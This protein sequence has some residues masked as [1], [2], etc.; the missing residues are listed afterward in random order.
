MFLEYDLKTFVLSHVSEGWIINMSK[1][2]KQNNTTSA[3][4]NNLDDGPT[5]ESFD[6]SKLQQ[7]NRKPSAK[8]TS[9]TESSLKVKKITS[10]NK[11]NKTSDPASKEK[12]FD[13]SSNWLPKEESDKLWLPTEVGC[14]DLHPNWWSGSFKPIKSKSWF[15]VKRWTPVKKRKWP[16]TVSQSS[17]FSIAESVEGE[18]S[19]EAKQRTSK[20]RKSVKLV[21]NK[22]Q[23][24]GLRPTPEVAHTLKRWFGCVRYT[25]NW[26]L[27]C[28]KAKPTQYKLNMIW[29]RKRFINVCNIPKDKKFL[30]DTPKSIRDN[31]VSDLQDA[32]KSNFAI[33]KKNPNH[34]FDI[35]FR[36]KKD[37]QAITITSDQIKHWDTNKTEFSM[38]PTFLK[39]KI[40]FHVKKNKS[41]PSNVSY[42]CK[43]LMSRLGKFSLVIV[44]HDPPCENQTGKTKSCSIDPGVRTALT[45]YCPEPGI[46]YKIG[47]G[48]ISR[49]YRLCLWLDKLI[50]SQQNEKTRGKRLAILRLRERIRNLVTEFHCKAVHFLLSKFNVIIL[51]PFNVSQMVKKADR[52]I[53]TKTVRQMLSWRHYGFRQ[54]LLNAAKMCN[55]TI[56][57]RG[58]EY[59][60]KTCTHCRNCKHNLGGAKIYKCTECKLKADRDCCGARNIFI[61]NMKT[62]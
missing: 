26:A 51:P 12:V 39:N 13:P 2:Q 30:L 52:K 14:P 24:V 20:I 28:I 34:T 32:F 22:S 25:Y 7:S 55:A 33:K 50:S 46:C 57:I 59:T 54:R 15:S 41:V 43:L 44:F 37:A 17:T 23:R 38:F 10:K 19:K 4:A 40:K 8:K 3:S 62:T 45:I 1:L 42:D 9:T 56:Y 48:D 35:K 11:S 36:N 6:L 61:K 29:L 49:I 31:A 47:D 27:G 18:N 53:S 58:E 5:K 60:S 16:N 21:A